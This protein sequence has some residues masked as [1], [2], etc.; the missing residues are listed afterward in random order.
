MDPVAALDIIRQCAEDGDGQGARE[1]CADLLG[2]L[3][4]STDGVGTERQ[5][6][7]VR[8]YFYDGSPESL[9]VLRQSFAN[10]VRG[11]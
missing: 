9:E 8:E 10:P 7:A 1:A 6:E 5:R 2:W 3:S 4:H 11:L